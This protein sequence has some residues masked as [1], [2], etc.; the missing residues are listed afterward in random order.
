MKKYLLLVFPSCL[1]TN[2]FHIPQAPAIHTYSQRS[3]QILYQ[4]VARFSHTF[5]PNLNKHDQRAISVVCK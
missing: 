3:Q 1:I 2:K 5:C 4:P